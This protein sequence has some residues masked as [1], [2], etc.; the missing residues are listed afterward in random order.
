MGKKCVFKMGNDRKIKFWEDNWCG[1]V[2]LCEA[3]LDLYSIAGTKGAMAA[4]LWVH[5]GVLGA[6]DPKFLRSFND[7]EMDTIQAFI[8]LT[9]NNSITPTVKDKMVWNGS[10]SGCFT[11]KAY[12]R[13]L[14]VASPH[15]VP[16]KML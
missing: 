7:W 6:R 11:V 1:R 10:N 9:S 14:E 3:F 8:D 12:F 2:P 16:T 4:D 13:L 15:S 5:Q